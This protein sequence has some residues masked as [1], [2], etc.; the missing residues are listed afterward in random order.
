MKT[1]HFLLLILVLA[2]GAFLLE[3][4]GAGPVAPEADG[5][6]RDADQGD[7]AGDRPAGDDLAALEGEGADARAKVLAET[8]ADGASPAAAQGPTRRVRAEVLWPDAARPMGRVEVLAFAADISGSAAVHAL[9]S[10]ERPDELPT[11]RERVFGQLDQGRSSRKDVLGSILSRT[12]VIDDGSQRWYAPLD[13]PE[14]A[15]RVFVHL[16]GSTYYTTRGAILD[17]GTESMTLRPVRGARLEVEVSSPDGGFDVAGLRFHVRRDQ[18]AATAMAMGAQQSLQ[19]F[20]VRGELDADGQALLDVVP[21]DMALVVHVEHDHAAE[22]SEKVDPLLAG[23]TEAVEITLSAGARVSGVV[24]DEEGSP[25]G[26]AEVAAYLPGRAFGFDDDEVRKTTAG[27]DGTF[28]L[29]GLPA[30]TTIIRADAQGYLEGDR[31]ATLNLGDGEAHEGLELKLGR[32]ATISGSVLDEAGA[33]VAG[34]TI[35]ALFDVAHMFG[36]SALNATRGITGK[37]TTA[38]DGSFTI[39]GLGRGPF[40]I[41]AERDTDGDGSSDET[42]RMDGL[43]PGAAGLV[44]TLASPINVRGVLRDDLG[45]PVR[46]LEVHCALLVSGSMGDLRLV[47]HRTKSLEDGTFGLDLPAGE[48][49][50]SVLE[51]THVTASPVVVSVPADTASP[52]EV[53]CVR[54]ATVTGQ[55][56]DPDGAPVEGAK[57]YYDDESGNLMNELM[58]APGPEATRTAADGT[59]ALLGIPPGE[60]TISATHEEFARGSVSQLSA[61][62]GELLADQVIRLTQGGTIEGICFDNEGRT[63]SNRIVTVQSMTMSAQRVVT[64]EADGTFRVEGLEPGNYQIVAVDPDMQ[65]SGDPN[66]A[67]INEMFKYMKLATAQVVEGE[68]VTVF[69]G[70]PPSDPVE[71]TGKVTQGNEPYTGAMITWL[72]AST[73][74]QEKMKFATTDSE[75]RY[76]LT[77]DEA[78]D[79]VVSV[80]KLPG[81]TAQQMTVEF[82]ARVDEGLSTFEKDIEIPGGS[83]AGVVLGPGGDPLGAARVTVLEVGGVRTNQMIG[84]SYAEMQTDA[85]G[86]FDVSGLRPGRYQVSAGGAMLFGDAPSAPARVTVGP[87]EISENGRISDVEIKLTDSCSV[88]V[89]VRDPAGKPVSQAS[90]FLRD[91]DGRHTE[92]FSLISTSPSGRATLR[93]LSEGTYTVA[94]RTTTHA[95]QE[96]EPFRVKE[97]E[98][99]RVELVIEP[100]TTVVA[101]VKGSGDAPVPSARVQLLDDRGRDVSRRIGLADVGHLYQSAAFDLAER[102]MGPFPPGEYTLVAEADDGRKAKRKFRISGKDAERRVSLRLR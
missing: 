101:V 92:L 102:R 56:L 37:T 27:P 24:T 88:D 100:G 91:G 53:T 17:P 48:W 43:Q 98:E 10:T 73:G 42:A 7:A 12:E 59:F 2:T 85:N 34:L 94:V 5:L 80:A 30:G 20:G 65:A 4:F 22:V 50:L 47:N 89:I 49:E 26:G 25:I 61:G 95:S 86:E 68:T 70:A 67:A 74:M 90:V 99:N 16:V 14:D 69:L 72:P 6:E 93:G 58:R 33:P 9:T 13:I 45:E 63:A 21:A 77:L 38:D 78:G 75:G 96:S 55:V 41:R 8:S 62:P 29:E 83:I 19:G 23:T 39:S 57:V 35:E 81:G 18:S 66:S 79:Y 28:A 11:K 87:L 84:G 46:D 15:G 36:P 97:G 76:S 40:S 1:K 71:V 32:G 64:S 52:L 31:A 60:I 82:D 51:E 54:A 44:L 3:R